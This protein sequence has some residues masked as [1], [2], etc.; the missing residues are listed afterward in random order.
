MIS[1]KV[2]TEQAQ[3][4]DLIQTSYKQ[5]CVIFK[6]STR[7]SVSAVAKYRLESAWNFVADEIT[8]YFLDVISRR[9]LSN[10]VAKA[11]EVYHESPQLLLI[12]NGECIYEASH[13]DISSQDLRDSF[14]PAS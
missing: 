14:Q 6:H 4:Q 9:A 8:P 7:C 1:W 3:I 5:P 10:E 13:L 12:R 2:L 11:F